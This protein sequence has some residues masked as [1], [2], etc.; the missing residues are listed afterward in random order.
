MLK[1]TETA[2]LVRPYGDVEEINRLSRLFSEQKKKGNLVG[3][4]FLLSRDASLTAGDIAKEINSV[5][6]D[7][8]AGNTENVTSEALAEGY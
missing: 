1:Q 5:Y 6:S 3:Y 8:L 7:H 2:T 4:S